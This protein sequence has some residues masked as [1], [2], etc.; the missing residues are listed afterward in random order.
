VGEGAIPPQQWR[1]VVRGQE[2]SE[3]QRT[4]LQGEAIQYFS[5]HGSHGTW[6]SSLYLSADRSADAVARVERALGANPT[7]VVVE[8]KPWTFAPFDLD[9]P[10]RGMRNRLGLAARTA[11]A[12][13][14]RVTVAARGKLR[15]LARRG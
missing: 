11:R 3:D 1:V 14:R 9:A 4:R 5:G 10:Q 6:S 13:A 7:A 8:A 2:L 15:R 12:R